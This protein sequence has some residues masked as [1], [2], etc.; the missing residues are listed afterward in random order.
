MKRYGWI[1]CCLSG[2]LLALCCPSFGYWPLVFVAL[3]PL[4]YALEDE[5]ETGQAGYR[6]I[7]LKGFVTGLF[8][9]LSLS[10]W[11]AH[12][13]VLA[14]PPT[15][16]LFACFHG[17]FAAG[18]LLALKAGLKGLMLSLWTV[19]LWVSLEVLGSDLFVPIPSLAI[20]YVLWP[21]PLLIQV[22]DFTGVFGVSFWIISVNV[23]VLHLARHGFRRNVPWA[24]VVLSMSFFL[25]GYALSKYSVRTRVP[26]NRSSIAINLVHTAVTSEYKEDPAFRE[27]IFGLLKRMTRKSVDASKDPPDLCIWP[28]TSV[29]V[30]L[31][32]IREKDF[33]EGLLALAREAR[34]SV[35]VGALSFTRE[36]DDKFRKFNA[37]FLV[38][39]KG[40]I[41]QEY[42]KII[43][44]P[45]REM[46]PLGSVLPGKLQEKWK[47]KLDAGKQ[48][49][50]MQLDTKDKFGVVICYEVLFPNLLRQLVSN[51]AGF[52]VN[53][54]NDQAPFGPFRR[55][56]PIPLAHVIYRA[57]E[58]RRFLVRCANWGRSLV[59]SP[60]GQIIDSSAMGSTGVL[61]S[62]ILPIY[63]QTF[64]VRHGF[65]FAKAALFVAFI[66]ATVLVRRRRILV[67]GSRKHH[68][69]T[70]L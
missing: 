60:Q 63:E 29:P 18:I 16:A 24:L 19:L 50:L 31:R 13:S 41:A 44:T 8:Y 21:I 66:W 32:T 54:T 58:T 23:F 62:S 3:V 48:L 10:F 55:A 47:S 56:Y 39:P 14:V 4:L 69:L 35:L 26:V 6:G 42:H 61:T 70:A 37:A 65:L 27:R 17:L 68:S 67:Q 46:N 12:M 30:F 49:G 11:I 33:L 25:V 51:G 5:F 38:P 28:E 40:Y 57:V 53:I 64:L 2:A 15:A 43:L 7:F 9:T 20:G 45:F 59:V 1:C 52:L 22:S 34:T 36:D